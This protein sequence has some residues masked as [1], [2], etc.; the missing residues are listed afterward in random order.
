MSGIS[1]LSDKDIERLAEACVRA[2]EKRHC[3]QIVMDIKEQSHSVKVILRNYRRFKKYASTAVTDIKN[4][5]KV[6]I[7]LLSDVTFLSDELKVE[8]IIKTRERTLIMIA[9]IDNAIRNYRCITDVS[10]DSEAKRRY[11]VIYNKFIAD[12]YMTIEAMASEYHID[13]STVY[14]DIDIACEELA[15]LILGAFS[16]QKRI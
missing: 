6:L 14:R 2:Y 3:Q 1:E 4:A 13:K 16:I 8:S 5:Q 11:Q 7:S 12:K 15:P 10:D 9:Q